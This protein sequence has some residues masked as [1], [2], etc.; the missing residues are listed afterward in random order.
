MNVMSLEAN[1]NEIAPPPVILDG[2]A[3]L[4]REK[5]DRASFEFAHHLAEHPLFEVP[6]LLELSRC[7]PDSDIYFN[8]GD[9]RVEQ[10]FDQ[11]RSRV[12]IARV[13]IAA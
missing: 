7:L 6:R 8:A 12:G 4:F 1:V 5:F 13:I 2:D 11:V 9:I 10:R 3:Q